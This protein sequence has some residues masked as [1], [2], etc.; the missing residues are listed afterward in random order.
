MNIILIAYLHEHIIVMKT[1]STLTVLYNSCKI[2][3]LRTLYYYCYY[4][5]FLY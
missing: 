5:F 3:Y 2:D 1:R 4:F